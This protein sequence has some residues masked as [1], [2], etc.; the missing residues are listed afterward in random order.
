MKLN[1]N[2][3]VLTL[4]VGL[5]L[6][7][8]VFA[9]W[10]LIPSNVP[11]D[12]GGMMTI[13]PSTEWNQAN[14]RLGPQTWVWT[15]D[16]IELNALE[17]FAGVPSGEPIYKDRDKK[18]NP[19]PKFDANA[20]ITDQVDMFER[21]FRSYNQVSNFQIDDVRPAKLGVVDGIQVR[22][23]FSR[24]DDELLRD[25]IIRIAVKNGR[26]FAVEF[27]APRLHYFPDGLPEVQAI[28]DSAKF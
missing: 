23:H 18:R 17:I 13:F 28:M 6:S 16:S 4:F 5:S 2:I 27:T 24:P 7:T 10:K 20:L 22:F 26:F 11:F 19:L 1:R 12:L 21:T 14:S 9:G 25:G 8:P 3:T 15:H